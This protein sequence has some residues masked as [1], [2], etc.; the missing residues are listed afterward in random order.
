MNPAAKI[1]RVVAPS[2]GD[3]VTFLFYGGRTA[4]SVLCVS[5]T[6]RSVGTE[7]RGKLMHQVH[8][9]ENLAT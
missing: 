6:C 4:V 9:S 1:D 3:G 2:S 8:V 5:G 7:A